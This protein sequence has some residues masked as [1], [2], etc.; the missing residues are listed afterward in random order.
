MVVPPLPKDGGALGLDLRYEALVFF[1]LAAAVM[2]VTA[3]V[4][5]DWHFGAAAALTSAYPLGL[6]LFSSTGPYGL[7][8]Y[9][10]SPL[11][12]CWGIVRAALLVW[13]TLGARR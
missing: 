9:A 11:G 5:R 4:R 7:T 8:A 10:L 1:S 12:L 2:L 13:K 6:Q 3:I